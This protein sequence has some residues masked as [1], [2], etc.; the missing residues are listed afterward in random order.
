[1][2][3]LIETYSQILLFNGSDNTIFV[4]LH[5]SF[6]FDHT[7]FCLKQNLSSVQIPVHFKTGR[8]SLTVFFLDGI[9][10]YFISHP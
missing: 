5:R 4:C 1:M 8:F 10:L 2:K 6:V 7:F 9:G 3:M